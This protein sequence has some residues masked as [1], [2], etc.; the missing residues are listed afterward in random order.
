MAYNSAYLV[1]FAQA[2]G[3]VGIKLWCYDTVDATGTVDAIGYISDAK[4]KGMEKGDMVLVRIWTTAVPAAT[5]EKQTADGV[6][7]IIADAG[8]HIVM[9]ISTAGAADL[10]NET[11]ITIT[12]SD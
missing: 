10:S 5:S 2:A 1:P 7:N 4:E 11:A 6:A 8:W 3:P 12:N 9:G